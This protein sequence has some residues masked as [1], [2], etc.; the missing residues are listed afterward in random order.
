MNSTI[1][2]QKIVSINTLQPEKVLLEW[3]ETIADFHLNYTK[4][5]TYIERSLVE[6]LTRDTNKK[7]NQLTVNQLIT[8]AT[9]MKVE[10]EILVLDIGDFNTEEPCSIE[11][12]FRRLKTHIRHLKKLNRQANVVLSLAT[13]V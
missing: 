5:T 8:L 13:S 1:P 6:N 10:L 9:R 2:S 12:E 11:K 4:L 7:P 3:L